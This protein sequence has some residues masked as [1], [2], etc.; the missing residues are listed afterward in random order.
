MGSVPLDQFKLKFWPGRDAAKS[1]TAGSA[2]L[3][4]VAN[5]ARTEV[6][7]RSETMTSDGSVVLT[8]ASALA[9]GAQLVL[10]ADAADCSGGKDLSA[11]FIVTSAAPI[12]PVF[13]KLESTVHH[14]MLEVATIA[15]SCSVDIDAA[16]VDLVL[17][18]DDAAKPLADVIVYRLVLDGKQQTSFTNSLVDA[19]PLPRGHERVYAACKADDKLV[20]SVALGKHSARLRGELP[21]GAVIESDEI[22]FELNCGGSP[23]S[24]AGAGGDSAP[25]RPSGG[26]AGSQAGT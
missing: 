16:W 15:G 20:G 1:T 8:P 14:S 6:A 7:L 18:L 11:S 17:T 4:A 21:S 13:G 9:A 25:A 2:R 3:Y 26:V 12:P 23:P 5:G 19:E 24:A 22:V 10:E